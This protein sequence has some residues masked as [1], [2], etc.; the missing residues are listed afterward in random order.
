MDCTRCPE[1]CA[2]RTQ[3]VKPTPAPKEGL[4]GLGEAPGQLEDEIRRDAW[5]TH[6]ATVDLVF[7]PDTE[8][9]WQMI[10]KRKGW[11]YELL[12]QM[13]EDPSLN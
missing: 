1:L 8:K 3:I 4:L 6:P 9:L 2:S 7:D 10:L 12:A 11:R 13:P 5:L